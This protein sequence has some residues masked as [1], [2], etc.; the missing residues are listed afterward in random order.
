MIILKIKNNKF[1][2]PI[3]QL[4]TGSIIAQL[5]TILVSPISTRLFTQEQLG[6]Y[7]LILTIVSIF[8]PVLCWRYDMSIVTS[9]DENSEYALVLGST[10]LG[11]FSSII[12]SIFY[13]LYI[14]GKLG[15]SKANIFVV[16]FCLLFL[17]IMTSL[18]NVLTAFNNKHKEYGLISKVYVKRNFIQN[19]LLIVTGYFK[20]GYIGLLFS[21]LGSLF[22]GIRSQ[23]VSLIAKKDKL[24]GIKKK[25]IFKELSI[26]KKQPLY[27]VPAS[28]LN[29]SSYS[30][31]NFFI[32]A[33]FGLKIFGLY[34]MSYR[35]L[36][37]PLTLISGNISKVFFQVASD[38]YHKNNSYRNI[39]KK[40]TL[41]LLCIAVPMSTFLYFFSPLLFEIVFGEGWGIAGVYVKILAPMYGIRLIVSTVSVSLIISGRQQLELVLQFLFIFFSIL[42]FIVC[43]YFYLSEYD[44]FIFISVSYSIIYLLFYFVI[45]RIS[46]KG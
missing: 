15:G 13:T 22:V 41:L 20:M 14:S 10:I 5:L 21:Q 43:K 4:T 17:L 6:T 1:L 39:L 16:F 7:T 24:K 19:F 25:Q 26:E 33:L 32:T 37:L 44:F 38:S 35:I 31:L 40:Y 34:S 2:K 27:S 28:L 36:G 45:Y 46:E 18:I 12:V 23:S 8:G 9:K 3:I 42:S 30:I 11:F 29:S